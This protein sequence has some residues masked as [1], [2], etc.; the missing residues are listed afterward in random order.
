MGAEA[1]FRREIAA[2]PNTNMQLA[3]LSRCGSHPRHP[4]ET[5]WCL[6]MVYERAHGGGRNLFFSAHDDELVLSAPIRAGEK[7]ERARFNLYTGDEVRA[8]NEGI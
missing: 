7:G 2:P 6:A 3:G 8:T 5:N 4:R 1:N